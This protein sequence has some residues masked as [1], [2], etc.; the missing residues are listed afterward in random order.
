MNTIRNL[1]KKKNQNKKKKKNQN[2]FKFLNYSKGF[3]VFKIIMSNNIK[4]IYA[5]FI[6][7]LTLTQHYTVFIHIL[8]SFSFITYS[9][10]KVKDTKGNF[11]AYILT[12]IHDKLWL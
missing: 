4:L 8:Y 6:F 12:L 11:K 9:L 10:H 1:Q 2:N 3:C 7:F 5:C